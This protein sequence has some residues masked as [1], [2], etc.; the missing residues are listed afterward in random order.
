MINQFLEEATERST[1]MTSLKNAG[2]R[3]STTLR[4]DYLKIGCQN[5]QR[6]E[7]RRKDSNTV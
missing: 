3:S 2:G 1:A 6:E 4:S 5:W 7:E